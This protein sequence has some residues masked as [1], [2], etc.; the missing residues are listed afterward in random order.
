VICRYGKVVI[1]KT[2]VVAGILFLF[3][4]G[5]VPCAVAE[6]DA[7]GDQGGTILFASPENG[8]V[9]IGSIPTNATIYIDGVDHG[10]TD[11][12]V[13]NLTAGTKNLSLVKTGYQ[14]LSTTFEVEADKTVVLPTYIL[15][16]S[17]GPEDGTGTV[18]IGSIPTNATIY[19]D[20]VDHGLTDRYV[21]NLTA[22]IRNLSLVKTGYQNL[23]TTFEVEADK[24]V[25][26]PT[27]ILTES[28]G[29]EDGTGTVWIGSIPTNATIYI[30]GVDH[31]L[32]DRYMTNLTAGTKNLTLVKTGYQNL[33]TTFE[34]EADKTVVLP[35]YILTE[36]AGPEDG[37][38]TVW[39][40]SI[41]T[42]AT[43]YIDGVDHGL[44]DRYVTNLTA[45]TK[46]LT[47]VK[48][49]YQNLS[50]TFEVEADKTVVLPTYILTESA[51]PEDGTGTVWI[52]SIPTN[53]TIYIDGVD[54]GLT[55]RYVT[56][57][58]AG[59]KNMTLVKTGYQNLSTT[60]EV[61]ADKT[62]V[63]PTFIFTNGGS[64]DAVNGTVW[65]GS[66]PTNATIYID[67]VNRGMTNTYVT[68]LTAGTKNL[69]LVKAGYQNLST[70]FE[71]EA[72]RT[73]VLRTFILANGGGPDDGTGTVWVGSIPTNATIYIDGV[74]RGMTNTYV[75]NLTAGT[76]NLTLVKTGYQNL[77][78]TFEVEAGRTIVLRTFILVNGGGPD[79]GTGTVW[80]GS[81]PTNAMIYI[82]G[83][84]RGM[85]NLYVT[86]LTAGIRNLTLVKAGYQNLSTTFE[87]EAGRTI[88]LRTFIL[89]QGDG[90]VADSGT[91]WIGSVPTR[92]TIYLDGINRGQTDQYLSN[93]PAGTRNLT[94]VKAGYQNLT[95]TVDVKAGKTTVMKAFRLTIKP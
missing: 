58:T 73:I 45:G 59:T 4:I 91:I 30:D 75:T 10:L 13:T 34:V 62:G 85:T 78:T 83:V 67:G 19:I 61:E 92:A 56:N 53:A 55:D 76:K 18:W 23:S 54:H 7:S 63:L 33:S 70:T 9:W 49:G 80:I 69:T 81:I 52:G 86:N 65:V 87:V 3:L 2:S 51:G 41:P 93:V 24:T 14:N 94:L 42:N 57:L 31:G 60:F 46:N 6:D 74:N 95:T 66:I 44:T 32:T 72:G 68:N 89:T 64:P 82:D 77:S 28:A 17:A 1:V 40:G 26:L 35:T 38:G 37:T 84:N 79:D 90:P 71:V 88:V 27:Y 21:T 29:P 8:T 15:T 50:T 16:E 12:Y 43:I 11:R 47:L 25:V 39:I 5:M 20:G 36:S 22:G 48:A